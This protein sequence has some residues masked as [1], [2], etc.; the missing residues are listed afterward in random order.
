MWLHHSPELVYICLAVG[1]EDAIKA[2]SWQVGQ[3]DVIDN[4][5]TGLYCAVWDAVSNHFDTLS[6]RQQ[7]RERDNLRK[8]KV[9]V[10]ARYSPAKLNSK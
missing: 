6:A 3:L 4:L 1:P 2:T 8:H 10:Q 7:L 9:D 5:V